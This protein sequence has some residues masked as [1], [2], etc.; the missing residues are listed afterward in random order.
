MRSLAFLAS[1]LAAGLTLGFFLDDT[2][3]VE[4]PAELRAE[5]RAEAPLGSFAITIKPPPHDY[6]YLTGLR[7]E[8]DGAVGLAG[9]PAG[10]V[11]S[12]VPLSG[13]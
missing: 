1:M 9:T 13:D 10:T 12:V 8:K 5:L 4:P 7:V 3:Q 11:I 6:V 2:A